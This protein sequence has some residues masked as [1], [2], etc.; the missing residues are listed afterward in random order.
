MEILNSILVGFST[1]TTINNLF[2]S[3]LGVTLGTL[4]GILPGLGP[5]TAMA[6]LIPFSFTLNDNIWYLSDTVG[7]IGTQYVLTKTVHLFLKFVAEDSNIYIYIFS[8][9]PTHEKNFDI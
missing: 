4:V 6:L 3:L 9:S 7:Y 2:Y 1:A 5:V 8:E